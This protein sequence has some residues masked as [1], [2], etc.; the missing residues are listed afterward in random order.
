MSGSKNK[1]SYNEYYNVQQQKEMVKQQIPMYQQQEK[2]NQ[3]APQFK[4][5]EIEE[6]PLIGQMTK[7]IYHKEE[8]EWIGVD[9]NTEDIDFV[10]Y[11][12]LKAFLQDY[13]CSNDD[14][15]S[16]EEEK[17]WCSSIE[18][19]LTRTNQGS[20][21]QGNYN[22]TSNNRNYNNYTEI[23]FDGVRAIPGGRYGCAQFVKIC[24]PP[25]L[26]NC[27]LGKLNQLV[28]YAVKEDVLR[29]HK[30]LLVWTTKVDKHKKMAEMMQKES[31]QKASVE[32]KLNIVKNALIEILAESKTGMSLAQLPLYLKRKL[33]FVLDL[34]ELGFPKLKDLI[35]SMADRIKLELRGHNHP[36]AY[37]I[38]SGRFVHAQSNSDDFQSIPKSK[39]FIKTGHPNLSEDVN[40]SRHLKSALALNEDH[41]KNVLTVFYSLM[42]EMP[43]GI[44]SDKL[45]EI[46]TARLG[47]EFNVKDYGCHSLLEFLKKFVIP[48]YEIEIIYV[49]KQEVDKFIIRNRQFYRNYFEMT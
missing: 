9:Q 45:P 17:K 46:V 37:L 16:D 47:Q 23:D 31:N 38:K 19:A 39:D 29:Y 5:V 20:T 3:K 22:Q 30:T 15:G 41:M 11:D 25:T 36:F 26:K 48:N 12:E 14:T 42:R 35:L 44:E 28:Q 1:A 6:D 49:S 33:P 7:A 24:G 34:N 21:Y 27:S 13:F 18:N 2:K 43:F 10:L 32:A 4:V 8:E 40:I